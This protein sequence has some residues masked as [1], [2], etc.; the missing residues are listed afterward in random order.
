MQRM[1]FCYAMCVCACVYQSLH[2][3]GYC[4]YIRL[5]TLINLNAVYQAKGKA[6]EFLEEEKENNEGRRVWEVPLSFCVF[7]F[8]LQCFVNFI[9]EIRNFND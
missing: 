6:S 2:S 1:G 7:N 5:Y 9:V 4:T 3:V 8:F